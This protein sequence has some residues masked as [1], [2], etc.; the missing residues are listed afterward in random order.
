[1]ADAPT[2]C[3]QC[4]SDEVAF[5]AKTDEWLC[6]AV[7]C[8]HRWT[9][10]EP[11][12]PEPDDQGQEKQK[13]KLFLSYGRRDTSDLAPAE[14]DRRQTAEPLQDETDCRQSDT[15]FCERTLS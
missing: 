11:D 15:A 7:D 3:P 12:S 2:T 5:I 1:M 9:V 10:N 8:N 14:C 4:G 6:T 13:V